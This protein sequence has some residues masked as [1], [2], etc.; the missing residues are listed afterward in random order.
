MMKKVFDVISS[1]LDSVYIYVLYTVLG[2]IYGPLS[3]YHSLFFLTIESYTYDGYGCNDDVKFDM[4]GLGLLIIGIYFLWLGI[5]SL[6]K[7]IKY[8]KNK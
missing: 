5:Y 3:I 8:F 1:F 2:F 7:V 4:A 6:V